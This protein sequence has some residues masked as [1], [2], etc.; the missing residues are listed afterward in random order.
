MDITFLKWQRVFLLSIV[1]LAFGVGIPTG[2]AAKDDK[3]VT[4]SGS[5]LIKFKAGTK[6]SEI[7]EV[8]EYY[9]ASKTLPLSRSEASSHKNPEQWLKLGFDSVTDVKDIARR[10]VQDT[11]VDEVDDV[12]FKKNR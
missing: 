2:A 5:F 6:N 11:R 10:I 7:Q 9:G 4:Q 8:T 1:G 3:P 12:V